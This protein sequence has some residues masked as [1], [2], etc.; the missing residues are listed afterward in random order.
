MNNKECNLCKD[1]IADKENSHII[2][3][4]M[5]KGLFEDT[6]PRHSIALN[7]S[8]KFKNIQDTPKENNIFCKSCEKRLEIIETYFARKIIDIHNYINLKNNFE[9]N[10]VSNQEYLICK[11]INPIAFKIFIYTLIWRTS[12]SKLNEFLK[13]K[14]EENIEEEL[15]KFLDDNL[16]LTHRELVENFTEIKKTPNYDF[17]IF[18]PKVKSKISRGIFTTYN[19][20]EN[21]H[22]LLIVDFAI[23]FFTTENNIDETFKYFSNKQN[24]KVIIPLAEIEKWNELNKIIVHQM[25]ENKNDEHE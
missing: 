1:K 12:I 22:I 8:G 4:F 24:E 23:Y 5:C 25:L 16:K 18:K 15:R 21:S 10:K 13:F 20:S 2:P 17:C 6:K 14:I 19:T 11:N 3:K 7:Q 9:F